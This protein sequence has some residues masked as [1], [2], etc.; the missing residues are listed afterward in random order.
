MAGFADRGA[1]EFP[2]FL[3]DAIARRV[4]VAVVDLLESVEVEKCDDVA[5]LNRV[6]EFVAKV[7]DFRARSGRR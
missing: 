1:K 7:G 4:S 2:K 5:R 3:Q 6:D